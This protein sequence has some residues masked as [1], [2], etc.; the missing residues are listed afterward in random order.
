M[1]DK[2]R[3]YEES[4]NYPA[5]FRR[6]FNDDYFSRFAETA[7]P[8]V[9]VK[10]TKTAFKLEVSAPGFDKKDFNVSVDKNILTIS[11]AKEFS[12]EE[13][14]DDEKILRQEFSSSTFSRSFTLPEHV[15]TEKIEAKEKNGVL[16]LKL[17]KRADA[18]EKAVKKI[19]IK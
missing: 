4:E 9:N 15:D 5:I 2:V 14:D 3:K 16:T 11:A 19:E 1:S 18:K 10:E 12:T 6:F 13:K 17:P 7:L 8:A